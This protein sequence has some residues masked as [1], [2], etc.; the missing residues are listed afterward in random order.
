MLDF[1]EDRGRG[2]YSPP[3]GP[4]DDVGALAKVDVYRY[5]SVRAARQAV[6]Q[7]ASY[8]QR[9]PKVTEWVC[10]QCDGIWTTWRTR[11]P[12]AQVGAQSVAWRFR[13]LSNAKA[14]GYT[15]V[16]RRGTTVVRVTV[17]RSRYPGDGPFTYPER[18]AKKKAVALARIAL[19]TAS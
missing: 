14:K 9:C 6:S 1:R 5:D 4:S 18:I 3:A 8:P 11:V 19:R 12:A 10:T 15:I 2:Y 13:E 17:G 16:A 7:N